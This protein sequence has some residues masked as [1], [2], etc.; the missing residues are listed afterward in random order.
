MDLLDHPP[1]AR[2]TPAAARAALLADLSL[3]ATPKQLAG[4]PDLAV[5]LPAGTPVYLPALDSVAESARV[6]AAAELVRAGLTPVP[7]L[8]ARRLAG[9]VELDARLAAWREVGVEAVMLIAGD[10]DRPVGRFAST[11]DVLATGLL[12]RHGICRIGVAGHP[13]GHPVADAATLARALADKVAYARAA[14][15]EMWIVTQFAFEGG[16]LAAFEQG[17]RGEG[18]RLTIRAGLPG[19][20]TPRR[21]MA[22]AWQCGVGVSARVLARR[23]AAARLLGRWAPDATLDALATHN[24]AAPASLIGGVHLYPFGGL[25]AALDWWDDARRRAHP[26]AEAH[27]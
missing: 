22:Y 25:A 8:A 1:T 27:P 21:L 3:E 15:A 10:V 20:A 6:A 2:P 18:L 4:V 26:A 14:G 16:P 17:L 13:E 19:P 11:L 24:A 9:P 7:H 5:R 12:E 23:P